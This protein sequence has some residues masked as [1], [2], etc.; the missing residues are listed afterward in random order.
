MCVVCI[1]CNV[2]Y[3]LR[4]LAYFKL[5]LSGPAADL[6]SGVFGG[7]V[8]E[9]MTDL[10]SLLS[11]LVTPGGE[12]LI[13]GIKDQI[14]PLT[15]EEKKRYD[16]IDIEVKDFESAIGAKVTI[17]EDKSEVLMARMRYPS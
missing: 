7:T 17:S 9:P 1:V 13:P 3:G 8:H 15:E 10:C 11:K 2:A 4:G 16:V 14:A 5:S 12:I 6:H